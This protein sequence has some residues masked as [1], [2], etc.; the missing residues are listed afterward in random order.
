CG[1]CAQDDT[2]ASGQKQHPEGSMQMAAAPSGL[3][4]GSVARADTG[5]APTCHPE[6]SE[7]ESKDLVTGCGQILRL[8][9]LRSLRS[10]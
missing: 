2:P 5:S 6:W 1:H 9:S 4:S 7:A 8:R 10:G 3:Q